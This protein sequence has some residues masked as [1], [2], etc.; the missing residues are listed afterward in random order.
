MLVLGWFEPADLHMPSSTQSHCAVHAVYIGDF[1]EEGAIAQKLLFHSLV[2]TNKM[3][4]LGTN[5]NRHKWVTC[6]HPEGWW[7]H[8]FIADACNFCTTS[9]TK[10]CNCK[11]DGF[12]TGLPMVSKQIVPPQTYAIG[13]VSVAASGCSNKRS[14]V[15]KAVKLFS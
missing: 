9:V 3:F 11:N 2:D 4:L 1:P 6:H 14:N 12:Q 10:R 8:N 15:V 13:W 7:F 5:K